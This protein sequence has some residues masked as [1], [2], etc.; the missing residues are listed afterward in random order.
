MTAY[1]HPG[2]KIVIQIPSSNVSQEE[3]TRL[4]KTLMA[5]YKNLG[6]DFVQVIAVDLPVPI[7]IISVIRPVAPGFEDW[8]PPSPD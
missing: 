5:I 2:D 6:I 3:D 1:L 7:S 8:L 4:Q